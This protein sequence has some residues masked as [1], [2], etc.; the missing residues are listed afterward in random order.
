MET[1]E[2]CTVVGALKEVPIS[3]GDSNT[4]LD[5]LVVE[6]APFEAIIGDPSME[7]INGILYL[8]L[9]QAHYIDGSEV[10]IKI[11]PHYP[12]MEGA[13][14]ETDTEDFSSATSAALESPS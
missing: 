7:D 9:R 11:T 3:F 14:N 10:T 6:G 5:F 4:F 2:S 12:S 1:G 8:G 13:G